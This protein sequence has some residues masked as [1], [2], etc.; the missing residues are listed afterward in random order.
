MLRISVLSILFCCAVIGCT[1][2][3]EVGLSVSSPNGKIVFDLSTDNLG[4]LNYSLTKSGSTILDKSRLGFIFGNAEPFDVG[5][6]VR[7]MRVGSVDQIWEQPWG[8]RRFIRD[9][10]NEMLVQVTDG[11][12]QMNLR[13]K[14]FDDGVGFRYEFP[15]N[16][17]NGNLLVTDELTQFNLADTE[18]R[19]YWTEAYNEE[20]YEYTHSVGS[21]ADIN[22]A[23]TPLTAKISDGR[24]ITVH[25]AAL[26]AYSSFVLRRSEKD[27]LNV[28]L[29]PAYDGIKV[30]KNGAF[31]TPWRT[32]QVGDSATELLASNLILNLNEPNRL[33]DVSWI[34]PGIYMGIWWSLHTGEQTWSE[35]P[36][37]GATTKEA[38]RYIDFISEHGLDGFL[39]EGWN[40]GWVKGWWKNKENDFNFTEANPRFDLEEIARFAQQKNVSLI[41]HN[42]T[43][44]DMEHYEEQ[45]SAAYELYERLG[46][47]YLKTGYVDF[48]NGYTRPLSKKGGEELKFA[49]EW[50][51]GQYAV[52]H[53]QRSVEKAAE[54]RISLNMHEAIKDTGLRRT[55]PNFLTRESAMGQEYKGFPPSHTTILPFTRMMAGPFDYTPGI[56]NLWYKGNDNPERIKSTITKQLGLM[57]VLYSPLQMAADLPRFYEEKPKLFQ[58]IKDVPADWEESLPLSAEIGEF[59]VYARQERGTDNWFI[60]GITNEDARM[61]DLDFSFLSDGNYRA[62]IYRDGDDAD[63]DSNPYSTQIDSLQLTPESKISIK[64]ASGGGFAISLFKDDQ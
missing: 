9:H 60:G 27:R 22:V 24:Y 7:K 43:A 10:N 35:G 18:S 3:Q 55:F 51:H 39:V 12:R 11:S 13:I 4:R 58:F 1:K 30:R 16:F 63:W 15:E 50:N 26:V 23:H 52:E 31:E 34:K 2:T 62:I 61:V 47:R 53:M 45:M 28:E 48:A 17:H 14:V 42:E 38:K 59:S 56:F 54:H 8:E 33:D 49:Y 64:M 20:R 37:L 19:L 25:E 29:V 36:K 32:I 44:G 6:S 57:V 41:L 21:I 40:T 5:L 46:V